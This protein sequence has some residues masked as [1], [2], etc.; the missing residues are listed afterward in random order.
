[1]DVV[2]ACRVLVEVSERGGV[3]RAAG[4]LGI[5]QSVA[6][7]RVA[8]LEHHLGAPLLERNARAAVLTPFGRTLVPTARRLVQLADELEVSADRA[9]SDPV[10][11]AVPET[12]A[13]RDLAVLEATAR[14]AGCHLD[15]RRENPSRRVELTTTGA[16]RVALLAVPADA[17]RWH[18][19]LGV[20]GRRAT[21]RP[22]RIE[23][24]RRRRGGR[25]HDDDAGN[26][27]RTGPEDSV[28]H[29]RDPLGRAGE[30]AG[31]APSQLPT[32]TSLTSSLAS[33]LGDGD[34]LLCSEAEATSLGLHW[35]AIVDLRLVRGYALAAES[36]QDARRIEAA[37]A[38]ELAVALGVPDVV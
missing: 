5:A 34:L 17:A 27:L 20:A 29:V 30:V 11:V 6:S 2:A 9:R 7:R 22:F 16:V 13:L 38:D 23:A 19:P 10:S 3:T 28:A 35:R 15:L 26:R 21:D 1:M 12:C 24:L 18:V 33:V 37:V 31:L 14:S 8:A 4:A 36:P 25:G 32:D